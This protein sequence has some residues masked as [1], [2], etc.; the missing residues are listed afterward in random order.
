MFEDVRFGRGET[1]DGICRVVDNTITLVHEKSAGS[2]KERKGNAREE[3]W[4]TQRA[5]REYAKTA[6]KSVVISVYKFAAKQLVRSLVYRA[7]TPAF[8]F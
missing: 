2:R 6:K 5:Q 7:V 3:R 4:V 8:R 1:N